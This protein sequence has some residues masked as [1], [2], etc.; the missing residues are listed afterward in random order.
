MTFPIEHDGKL[1]P[2]FLAAGGYLAAWTAIFVQAPAWVCAAFGL[3]A[4]IG[5]AGSALVHARRREAAPA[6]LEGF[7]VVSAGAVSVSVISS[8]P[9][10]AGAI[11]GG[12]AGVCVSLVAWAQEEGIPVRVP[13]VGGAAKSLLARLARLTGGDAQAGKGGPE[14]KRRGRRAQVVFSSEIP[15]WLIAS[16]KRRGERQ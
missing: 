3:D 16:R 15:D 14:R 5:G 13:P 10:P 2:T 4:V 7:A 9:I 8:V 11:A 6:L 12:A 1:F